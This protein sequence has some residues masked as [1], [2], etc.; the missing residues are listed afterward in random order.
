MEAVSSV[1]AFLAMYLDHPQLDPTAADILSA[2]EPDE[3]A[4]LRE[5]RHNPQHSQRAHR[6]EE[7]AYIRLR[8]ELQRRGLFR[9]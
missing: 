9:S 5:A 8:R 2:L 4:A 6:L 1:E 7:Q 3:R